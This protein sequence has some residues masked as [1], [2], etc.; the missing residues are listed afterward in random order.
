MEYI[1]EININEAVIHVLDNNADEPILN[2]FQLELNDEIYLFLM[3][4]IQ[5]A[6]GREDLRYATFNDKESW[7]FA[8]E[9]SQNYLN[10]ECN[11]LEAST[12]IATTMFEV[13]KSNENITSCDLLIVS[14]ST[15]FGVML[16]ILKLDYVKNYKHSI[17][18][19]NN[20]IGIN[21]VQEQTG[22]PSGTKLQKC[23]FIKPER[24]ENEFD[25]MIIDEISR[26][27]VEYGAEWFTKNFLGCSIIENER[28]STKQL[29][30]A[31]ERFVRNNY[32]ED[33]DRAEKV[34]NAVKETVL[35][36]E[37]IKLNELAEN[38]FTFHSEEKE[39]FKQDLKSQG[40]QEDVKV[41]IEFAQKK[42]A[43]HKI[44]VDKD[45]EINISDEAYSDKSKFEVVK[46]GDGSINMVIKNILNYVER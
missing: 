21:I 3:K 23:A 22:L 17:D 20:E 35:K 5:K 16:G 1:K 36:N 19:I 7:N 24:I 46:N 6:L 15:E 10:G 42:L 38:L 14:I 13:I 4:H 44:K 11:L 28:D 26:N 30:D 33:A 2:K 41:D 37:S 34:R 39:S 29:L 8:N 32:K 9:V 40:I 43:K 31:T 45:I 18:F 12:N 25:L 27:E